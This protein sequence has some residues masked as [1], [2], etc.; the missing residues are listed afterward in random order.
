[1]LLFHACGSKHKDI[2][3]YLQVRILPYLAFNLIWKS[4]FLL[5]RTAIP[6]PYDPSGGMQRGGWFVRDGHH[7]LLSPSSIFRPITSDGQPSL[8]SC[9]LV[10]CHTCIICIP[11]LCQIHYTC[12]HVYRTA[13]HCCATAV[14]LQQTKMPH[15]NIQYIRH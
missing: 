10:C 5:Y 1:M 7:L 6:Y 4:I 8:T 9:L 3:F 12:V 13:L 14:L 2:Q 15:E 11:H